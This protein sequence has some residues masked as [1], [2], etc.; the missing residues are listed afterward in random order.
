MPRS[1]L[2]SDRVVAQAAQIAD[3][4]GL[5]EVTLA[6]VA[7][8][9]GVRPPSLYNHI[10]GRAGLLRLL[11]ILSIRELTE[12]L[13]TA[14]VGRSGADALG[15]IARAYRAYARAHPGR[16]TATVWAPAPGDEELAAVAWEAVEVIVAV[17]AAWGF[18]DEEVLHRVRVIRSALHGFVAIEAAGGFGLPLDID[19]SFDLLLA[20]LVAGL[21]RSWP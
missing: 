8:Q 16:Y 18:G 2:D 7:Q 4:E 10:K 6:R 15:A 20:T 13:R 17:L 14:A 12:A 1:G 9:L 21:E 3:A 5:A 11:S 19:E